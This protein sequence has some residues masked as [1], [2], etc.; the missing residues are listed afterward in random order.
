MAFQTFPYIEPADGPSVS[1]SR[2]PGFGTEI[3]SSRSGT[4]QRRITRTVPREE[5]DVSYA[6]RSGARTI[7]AGIESFLR[8]RKGAAEA[9]VLFDWDDGCPHAAVYAGTTTGVRTVWNLPC[10]TTATSVLVYL[11]GVLQSS[12]FTVSDDGANSRK[13]ITFSPAPAAGKTLTV[14]FTGQRAFVARF[15]EDTLRIEVSLLPDLY[16]ISFGAVELIGEE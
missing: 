7:A 12:G 13:K 6:A 1:Y 4:E 10:R 15:R 11:D 2:G 14:S 3:V 8:A 16:Q 5:L 9:F